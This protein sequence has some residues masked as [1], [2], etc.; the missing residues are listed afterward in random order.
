MR[1]DIVICEMMFVMCGCVR[2][3]TDMCEGEHCDMCEGDV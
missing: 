3:N 2:V 1:V